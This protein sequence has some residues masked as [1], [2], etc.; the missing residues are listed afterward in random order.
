MHWFILGREKLLSAAEIS[1]VLGYKNIEF[2][3]GSPILRCGADVAD[4]N[5]L[6]ARLGGT[7]KIGVEIATQL[8]ESELLTAA[9]AALAP[10]EGKINF[11]IS[12]YDPNNNTAP[13]QQAGQIGTWGKQIKQGLK[14]SGRSVRHVFNYEP[15]LSS[16]TV[17]INKLCGRGVEFL[18]YK[19]GNKYDLARTVAVQP[20]EEFS[21]RD[22]GRPG[23]DDLSG[24]LP[25]KLAM[26][27]INIAGAKPSDTILDPFCGS[28][29]IIT[30]AMLMG[31]KNLI[32]SDISEKAI[33]D[34]K[35]NVE[36]TSSRCH[37]ERSEGSSPNNIQLFQSDIAQ[38]GNKLK[39]NSV[40]AIIA[41]PYLGKP[42]K[43]NE[44]RV[45]LQK[46]TLE[47][48]NLYLDAFQEFTKILKPNGTVVFLVPRFRAG[49]DWIII[50]I[51]NDI[52]KIG[53]TPDELLPGREALLYARANQ[54]VGR[55]VW[56]FTR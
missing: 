17:T 19:K 35:T 22:F 54:R 55:E 38:I 56:K 12:L 44:T 45:E 9:A 32:G 21:E 1:A 50:D 10:V 26:M 7:I 5:L 29:T 14:T 33:T 16:V 52:K 4:P 39:L 34:T 6:M 11:G 46:Q 36:W 8:T 15:I 3:D 53:F 31:Y 48:K 25:P 49:N 43:G 24:M 40:D 18:I 13:R 28:G 51:K 41:E 37:P 47:L 20:F 2:T 27:M 30:E 23:R 42:L